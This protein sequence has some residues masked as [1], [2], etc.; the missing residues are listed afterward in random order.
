MP[1]CANCGNEI[2]EDAKFCPKCGTAVIKTFESAL[3]ANSQPVASPKP[4]LA[5]WWERFLAWLIDVAIVGLVFSF[6]RLTALLGGLSFS[7]IP[8]WPD[9]IPFLNLDSLV[10]FLYWMLMEGSTGQSL[11]KMVMRIKIVQLDGFPVNMGN[12]AVQSV[13]KAFLLPLDL[14]IGWIVYPRTRQRLFNYFSR[15][16]VV[17]GS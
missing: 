8:G 10:V 17:K 5:F 11:G 16:V 1:F 2:P 13:G 9:W 15:T 7:L 12:A 3:V 6:L 14:L 4:S